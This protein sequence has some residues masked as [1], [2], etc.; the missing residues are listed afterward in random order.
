MMVIGKIVKYLPHTNR[1][2]QSAPGLMVTSLASMT[3]ATHLESTYRGN[4]SNEDRLH[5]STIYGLALLVGAALANHTWPS[6]KMLQWAGGHAA[7]F[8]VS[9]YLGNKALYQPGNTGKGL[10]LVWV[11]ALLGDAYLR[12]G[13]ALYPLPFSA[14]MGKSAAIAS[15]ALGYLPKLH[16]IVCSA[17]AKV[18]KISLFVWEGVKVGG[19]ASLW[20]VNRTLDSRLSGAVLST[21]LLIASFVCASQSLNQGRPEGLAIFPIF[22]ALVIPFFG[23]GVGRVPIDG[24]LLKYTA[25]HAA[26]AFANSTLFFSVWKANAARGANKQSTKRF[27]ANKTNGTYKRSALLVLW[28]GLQIYDGWLRACKPANTLPFVSLLA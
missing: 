3:L 11:A 23:S 28:C 25:A 6:A 17:S 10:A 4:D 7:I 9:S 26:L 27:S 21:G 16:S 18:S 14:L 2:L 15:R 22:L 8:G 12:A 1:A 24:Q 19:Q 20:V 13:S 5:R